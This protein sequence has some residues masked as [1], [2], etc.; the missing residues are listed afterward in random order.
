MWRPMAACPN[1]NSSTY[2]TITKKRN[3]KVYIYPGFRC[4]AAYWRC[5]RH[6][7]SV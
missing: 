1:Q 6:G 4:N 3:E 7:K 5:E 2:L